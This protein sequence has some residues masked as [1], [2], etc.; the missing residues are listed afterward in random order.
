MRTSRRSNAVDADGAV[1]QTRTHT[2]ANAQ[3][4]Q[5]LKEASEGL[6][7]FEGFT[8]KLADGES[9]EFGTEEFDLMEEKGLEAAAKTG[10]VLVSPETLSKQT[11]PW[12]YT[13]MYY[14]HAAGSP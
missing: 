14:H 13:C 10:F 3:A 1:C 12:P 7:P 4:R 5:L 2:R 8:P 9:L 6:N 11:Y